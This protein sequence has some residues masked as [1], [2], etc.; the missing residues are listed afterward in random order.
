MKQRDFLIKFSD[1]SVN[2]NMGRLFIF[3]I[4]H[5]PWSDDYLMK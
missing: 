4:F 1:A 2:K 3:K 5:L